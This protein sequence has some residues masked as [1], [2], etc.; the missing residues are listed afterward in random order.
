VAANPDVILTCISY[1][2]DPVGEILGREGWGEVAAVKNGQV[3]RLDDE[4]SNQPNHRI[5]IA[6][7]QMAEAVYPEVY[8]ALDAAA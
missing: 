4:S 3:Y 5:V 1:L 6:L 2:D 7:R 8:G